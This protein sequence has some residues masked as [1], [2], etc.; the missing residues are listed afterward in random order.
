MVEE[1]AIATRDEVGYRMA[2]TGNGLPAL[3]R[4]MGLNSTEVAEALDLIPSEP[5]PFEKLLS[6]AFASR[7]RSRFSDGSFG[8]FYGALDVATCEAEVVHHGR[9]VFSRGDVVNYQVFRFSYA[10]RTA[11]LVPLLGRWPSLVSD[12]Y[13]FCNLLGA[14][15]Q[16]A[17]LDGFL[18]PSARRRDGT[19]LPVFRG[20]ALSQLPST[21]RRT[22]EF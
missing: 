11:D 12:D 20:P 21:E 4:W 18:A 13:N 7:R 3:L 8:V 22:L 17:R 16:R 14:E 6:D 5:P 1:A 10:G 9:S 19:C 15:A 2:N